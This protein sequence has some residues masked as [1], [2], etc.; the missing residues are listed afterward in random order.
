MRRGLTMTLR[1]ALPLLVLAVLA[2]RFGLD[3]F[4]PSLAVVAPAPLAAALVLGA[5][6]VGAHA[7]RWRIVV[8]GAGMPLGRGEA[9]AE[10]YRSSALNAVLPGG[11]AGDVLRAWRQHTGAPRG[12]RPAAVSVVA[13][14]AAG[15]F[16]LLAGGA[17]VLL[18]TA[19]VVYPAAVAAAGA[20]LAWVFARPGLR[21]LSRRDRAA[22]WGWS[23]LALAAL[24]GL[25]FVVAA[26]MGVAGSPGVLAAFGLVLLAGTA[27]PLNLGGWG[28]REAAA[29]L[30]ATMLGVSPAVGVALAAGYGLLAAVSVLPGLVVLCANVAHRSVARAA[31]QVELDAYVVTE[32]EA[33]KWRPQSIREAVVTGEPETGHTVAHQ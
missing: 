20:G 3:A 16:V 5:V 7:A 9:V 2:H 26:T 4:R 8:H 6:A 12:W 11:V 33:P 30:A 13:E 24:L 10:Y 17:V 14:R 22:V 15:L 31:R 19:P 27:V 21:R 29:A 1:V 18:A 28:P 23:A 32:K 25:T